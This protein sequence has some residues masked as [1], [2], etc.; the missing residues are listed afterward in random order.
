M[1][2]K[3]YIGPVIST[4][5]FSNLTEEQKKEFKEG[6]WEIDR[7]FKS[8]EKRLVPFIKFGMEIKLK[9]NIT[10]NSLTVESPPHKWYG[11]PNLYFE[12]ELDYIVHLTSSIDLGED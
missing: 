10:K 7:I 6:E 12:S 4:Y 8:L 11:G 3:N 2:H 9:N 1:P 5:Q